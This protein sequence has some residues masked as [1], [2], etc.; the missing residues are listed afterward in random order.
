[1]QT[2]P[3]MP[4]FTKDQLELLHKLI[5]SQLQTSKQNPSLPTCS[6]AQVKQNKGQVKHMFK[7]F[8]VMVETQFHEKIQIL[9][10]DNGRVFFN[11][12]L[13]NFFTSK[14]IVHQ[15]SCPDTPNKWRS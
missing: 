15:S 12:Q 9:Q 4:P 14:T 1:M 13:G 8:Y 6:F 11:D 2:S 10:S 7:A 3:E 5:Q